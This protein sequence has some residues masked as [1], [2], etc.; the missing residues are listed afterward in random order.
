MR[1]PDNIELDRE[2]IRRETP[3]LEMVCLADISAK[4]IDWLW[5]YWIAIG[6]VSCLAGDG[7]LG[8]TTIL[9]DF[10]ARTTNGDS[11]PDGTP[12]TRAGSVIILA[13]EDDLEDTLKPRLLAVGA[14]CRRI[15]IIR[16]VRDEKRKRRAFNLQ[17]DLVQLETEI[18]RL[19][20]V[21]LV[22]IDP[23]SSYLGKGV[24]SHKNAEVRTVLEP[25]AEMASRLRVAVLCNNHFSKGGGNANSRIIGSVAFVNQARAAF[26][27]TND[28]E[29]TER[30]L[31]MPSKMNI[32]P[33]KYGLAYRIEGY[34]VEADGQD[35]LTSR[36]AWE[37]TPVTITADQ[38]LAA[39]DE[40]REGKT[41]KAEA[42]EFL[43]DLLTQGEMA[44]K[45]V[46]VAAKNAGITFKPLRNARTALGVVTR[47]EGFGPGAVWFWSLPG[48]IDAHDPHRCPFSNVGI[49]GHGGH[50]WSAGK[51]EPDD[52]L[53]I[54]DFLDRRTWR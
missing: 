18:I 2:I 17:A 26:I 45:D 11:W 13:A 32:A 37:T 14:D 52:G 12:G 51:P 42:T 7:G 29:D 39:H 27:V 22:I 23:V 5:K 16:A 49:N 34:A 47:R 1:I 33:I 19:G 28:A 30:L 9:C 6:K 15:F 25:L 38:A 10:A 4:P 54:P 41:A 50:L 31:L 21:R 44:A 8:K 24:D 3:G 43:R 46:D 35:I 53:G 40:K 48:T 20:N 36:I